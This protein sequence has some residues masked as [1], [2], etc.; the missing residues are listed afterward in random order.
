VSAL[1]LLLGLVFVFGWVILTVG[2]LL[3]LWMTQ[4]RH[5]GTDRHCGESA[6]HGSHEWFGFDGGVACDFKC[7]GEAHMGGRAVRHAV[8]PPAPPPVQHRRHVLGAWQALGIVWVFG[9]IIVLR[10]AGAIAW[11]TT[12]VLSLLGLLFAVVVAGS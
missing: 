12:V 11:P 5:G 2:W 3:W 6:N 10:T 1:W 9:S 4:G 7:P 8:E